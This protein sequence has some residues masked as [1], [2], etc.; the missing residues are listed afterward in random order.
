MNRR[1]FN[2]NL[3]MGLAMFQ[4][5]GRSQSREALQHCVTE[6]SFASGKIYRDP[7]N[8]IELDIIFRGP[9]GD[10]D[11]VP[12][13]WAGEQSLR[14]RYAPK[15]PGK[16]SW[17]TVS[18]DTS[19][20]DLHGRTGTLDVAP[21]QGDN[22]LHK[23][24]PIGVRADRR[25]FEHADGTPMPERFKVQFGQCS[26][27]RS[28][29]LQRLPPYGREIAVVNFPR[30]KVSCSKMASGGLAMLRTL[31]VVLLASVTALGQSTNPPPSFD[32]VQ[33]QASSPVDPWMSIG[34]L[35]DGH[36]QCHYATLRMLIAAAY[37]RGED[38]VTGGPA[39]LDTE[40]FDLIGP[41]H[42]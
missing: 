5:P 9:G 37:D 17:R 32:G 6:W 36:V 19:N 23:H 41:R 27:R 12:A 10:E 31:A 26:L 22:P 25:Y 14:A 7:F 39:W 29:E 3:A 18:S 40:R 28:A 13:F 34:L 11:R 35:P 8:E 38:L 4:M 42:L 21:Y 16:Y 30:R 1:T 2:R 24:G 33:I 15:A 20:A